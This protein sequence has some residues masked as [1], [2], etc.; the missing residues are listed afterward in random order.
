[1]G[2]G[3]THSQPRAS[4]KLDCP[5][6]ATSRLSARARGGA[7][8]AALVGG[9][10]ARRALRSYR[11]RGTQTRGRQQRRAEGKAGTG[12]SLGARRL[13]RCPR[14]TGVLRQRGRARPIRAVG[15][16]GALAGGMRARD[17]WHRQVGAR[18]HLHAPGGPRFPAH[19]LSFPA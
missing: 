7:S 19:R 13:G 1:M 8:S 10:A 12:I 2:A 5:L 3:C 17:G 14:C 11:V 6:S 16:A 18:G 15:A 9:R 4:R